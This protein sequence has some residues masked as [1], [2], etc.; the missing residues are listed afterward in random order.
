MLSDILRWLTIIIM[1]GGIASGLLM[2][3]LFLLRPP[4]ANRWSNWFYGWLLITFST[5]L[6]DKLLTFTSLAQKR[7]DL[8]FALPI[9][10]SFAFAPLVFFYVKSRLYFQYKASRRDFKHFILPTVQFILLSIVAAQDEAAK[11]AFSHSF[12][13]PFYG[14]FEKGV[15][16]LQFFLYLYF[17]YRFILHE[18]MRLHKIASKAGTHGNRRQILVVGW[19]KRMVKVLFILFGIHAFFILSDYFSYRFFEVNL[20]SKL[21]FSM[22][23]ELSFVAMLFWICLNGLFAWRRGL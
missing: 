20:Q 8:L 19:L 10:V 7:A 3:G 4:Q 5:T 16:I 13:S 9:Y 17:A 1:A 12:F 2:G 11:A 23:Y 18:K 22:A 14:N 15:F 21:L 6:L